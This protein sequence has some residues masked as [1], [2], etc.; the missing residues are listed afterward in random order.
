MLDYWVAQLG[1]GCAFGGP[2]GK[3]LGGEHA[4]GEDDTTFGGFLS[5]GPWC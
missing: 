5:F 3:S 4:L 1:G 2:Y